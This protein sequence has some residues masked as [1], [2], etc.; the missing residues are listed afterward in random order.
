MLIEVNG[1]SIH[2]EV[3]GEGEPLL[4]LHGFTG[5]L[6]NWDAFVPAWSKRYKVITVDIIG[7]GLSERPADP[8]RYTME[9]AAADLAALLDEL[10]IGRTRVLGYSMGGRLALSF[11]ALKPD[12]VSGL[13]L[14]SSSPGLA[15]AEEREDRVLRDGQLAERIER[16]GIEAFVDYWESIPL[17]QSLSRQPESV[18]QS[19]RQQRLQNDTLGLANSLRGMGTGAQPS[20][21]ERLGNLPMPVLLVAGGLDAKFD[22]L[23]ERMNGLMPDSRY[24]RIP[25]AGHLAHVEQP[26]I[27]GT[28]VMQFLASLDEERLV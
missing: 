22:R 4:L 14:E 15:E 11:A 1:I 19:I 5:S 16:D 21:W 13:I 28:I 18:R 20:W 6:R 7:H 12:R 17:F 23:A 9:Q 10:H 2:A 24:K 25:D 27:F 8:Q 26:R 3:Q